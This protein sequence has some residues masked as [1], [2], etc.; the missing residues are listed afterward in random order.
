MMP[1]YGAVAGFLLLAVSRAL[2][3]VEAPLSFDVASVKMISGPCSS[4]LPCAFGAGSVHTTP[5]AFACHGCPLGYLIRWAYSLHMYQANETAGPDWMEPGVNWVRYDVAA[6]TDNPASTGDLRLMLRTLLAERFKLVLHRAPK[7]MPAYV[8]SVGSGGPK[9][10]PSNGE[11]EGKFAF[12]PHS[13]GGN[14]WWTVWHFEHIQF[15][16]LYELLWGFVP[17][18]IVD[19]TGLQGRFD[20]DLNMGKFQDYYE[21][22]APGGRADLGPVLNRA[23]QEIGL[24]LE[25]KRRPVEVLVID[26]A[27]KTPL[28]N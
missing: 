18:P 11:G 27:E 17:T 25:L 26:H 2:A 4:A 9:L 20:F 13:A 3:Q 19:E 28:E 16:G 1:G 24:K 5:A 8:L 22:P 6:K 7:E 23:L 15:D 21:P 14:L 12:G 10:R